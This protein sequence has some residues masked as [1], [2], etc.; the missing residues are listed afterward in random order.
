MLYIINTLTQLDSYL[1]KSTYHYLTPILFLFAAT[2]SHA[3]EITEIK[4][5]N[6]PTAIT[7]EFIVEEESQVKYSKYAKDTPLIQTESDT[8]GLK[9]FKEEMSVPAIKTRFSQGLSK[10]KEEPTHQQ[11]YPYNKD[12]HKK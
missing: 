2:S 7:G 12:N 10:L 1:M 6:Q 4:T 5:I 3:A 11:Q 9:R 8:F